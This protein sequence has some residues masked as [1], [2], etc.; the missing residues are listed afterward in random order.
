MSKYEVYAG[1]G[2]WLR[3]DVSADCVTIHDAHKVRN[4]QAQESVCKAII[5]WDNI[6][7]C[8]RKRGW[9]SLRREW[10]AHNLLY[11]LPP[12]PSGWKERLKDVDLDNEPLYR[13]AVYFILAI[14]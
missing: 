1:K 2:V 13:R 10:R 3:V 8:I 11:R 4:R 14:F 9:R 6:P 5:H 12:L 7:A